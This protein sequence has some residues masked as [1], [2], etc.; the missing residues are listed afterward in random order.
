MII[1]L[2][3]V[4]AGFVIL[5]KGADFLVDGSCSIAKKLKIPTIIIG[6]TIVSIGTSMPELVVSFTSSIKGHSDLAIGNVVGSNI[7]N[8]FLILGI[9]A[10]IKPLIF[11][12]ETVK[13]EIPIVIFLT[14]LLYILGNN[15][16][17]KEIN[18]VEGFILVILCVLFIILNIYLA[19]KGNNSV[20]EEIN[21]SIGKAIACIIMGISGLKIGGDLV[22]N[23]SS[24]IAASFGISEK[25][26]GLTIVAFSTSL[27]ELITSVNATLKGEI[28]M[29]IRKCYGV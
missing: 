11:K 5:V 8:L 24:N 27:P 10:T 21:L 13:L 23:S 15:G 9:C 12:K 28:D 25:L 26:I 7:S 16:S 22:V 6:L 1:N 4:F 20:N 29:A 14:S 18:Q 17:K 19:K 2:L 3:F